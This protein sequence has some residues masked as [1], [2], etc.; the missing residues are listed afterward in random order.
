MSVLQ[1]Q[2]AIVTGAGRG[3][4]RTIAQDLAA[5]G[6]VVGLVARSAGQ[7]EEVAQA[8][9]AAGGRALALPLDVTD[10]T[11]VEAAVVRMAEQFGPVTL[12]VNNAG[13][14][15][16]YGPVH[17]VDPDEWWRAQEI[18]VRGALLF[19]HALLPTMR[20]R[21]CGRIINMA[22]T[23]AVV[24]GPSTSAYCVAKATLLRLTEHVDAENKDAGLAAFCIHPGTIM[25]DMAASTLAD[26]DA[27]KYAGHIVGFLSQFRDV[28]PAP[29]LA[30]LGGQCVALASGAYDTLAGRYLDLEKTLDEL[31]AEGRAEAPGAP[32]TG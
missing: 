11:A 17:V 26:P 13:V 2:V 14:D 22:S 15:R 3:L 9:E 21:R 10:R 6:A 23:A 31:V 29:E 16:P 20:E 27:L 30:R 7:L 32:V 18:H 12:L 8:I 19:M 28:D 5:A 4:G 25:T 24:V 1:G